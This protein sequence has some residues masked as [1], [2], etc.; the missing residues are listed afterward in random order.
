VCIHLRW[1]WQ[2]NYE[3]VQYIFINKTVQK[4]CLENLLRL[5]RVRVKPREVHFCG[6]RCHGQSD[7]SEWCIWWIMNDLYASWLSPLLAHR[8]PWNYLL[9]SLRDPAVD[10]Y[11][12]IQHLKTF[13]FSLHWCYSAL[14][15]ILIRRYRDMKW[16][17]ILIS[18]LGYDM[19]PTAHLSIYV[20]V[21]Y[22]NSLWQ[23]KWIS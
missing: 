8:S 7:D 12:F 1:H 20:Y 2:F 15:F 4:L 13:V 23:V 22:R 10:Q 17:D 5:A 21:L 11:C 3:C 6:P 19:N 14:G 18:W 16:H 9:V